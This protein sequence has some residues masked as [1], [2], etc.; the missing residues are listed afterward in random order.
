VDKEGEWSVDGIDYGFFP[1]VV[2]YG[3]S[4]VEMGE[5]YG[6][7]LC[8]YAAQMSIVQTDM[9]FKTLVLHATQTRQLL[10]TKGNTELV[11][12]AE[13]GEGGTGQG[14]IPQ[15]HLEEG[16]D[17]KYI[18]PEARI[19]DSLNVMRSVMGL[20]ATMEGIPMDVLDAQLTE[21]VSSSE[22]AR[23]RFVPL[24]Q[25]AADL[26]V[27]WMGYEKR[28]I[29]AAGG[30]LHVRSGRGRLADGEVSQL[31]QV[32]VSIVSKVLP[33][34]ENETAQTVLALVAGGLKDPAD[35][36][37]EVNPGMGEDRV[38]KLVAEREAMIMDG[39]ARA[40]AALADSAVKT[41]V[42]AGAAAPGV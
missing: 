40:Q 21:S 11:A 13:D 22:A 10:V 15:L 25:Q 17:A 23:I 41:G 12:G 1:G 7:S 4:M 38:R 27:R 14:M 5:P 34:T 2:C 28:L 24:M 39:R 16:A 19:Q 6:L 20:T 26:V 8:K 35:A 31:H 32:E 37:R 29:E 33:S 3:E 36:I 18:G 9:L 30:V 42:A